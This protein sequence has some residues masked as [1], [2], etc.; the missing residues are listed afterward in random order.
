[1]TEHR[2]IAITLGFFIFWLVIL[3]AGADHPPPPGFLIV[4]LFDLLAAMGV[5]FCVPAYA[6]WS[7]AHRPHHLLRVAAEGAAAGLLLGLITLLLP[8]GGEPT[9]PSPGRIEYL[10]WFIVLAGVGA[11]NTLAVYALSRIDSVSA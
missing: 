9:V 7:R 4:V 8:L 3:Y 2:R 1:M 10:I 5:Y 6:A 11:I